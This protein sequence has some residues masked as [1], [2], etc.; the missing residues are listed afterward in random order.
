M[1]VDIELRS[2]DSLTPHELDEIWAVTDRYVETSRPDFEA[3]LRALPEVALW[4]ADNGILIGL[5]SL[6]IY[7]VRCDGRTSIIFFTS[8]VVIDAQFR[9]SNALSRTGMKVFLRETLRRPWLPAYWFF[10]SFSY[11]SYVILTRNLAEFWP[12]RDREMP[13]D[14][15][16]FIDFLARRRYGD[17]WSPETGVVHHSGK[18]RLR[19][20]TAPLDARL[21]ADPDVRF[22]NTM[23]PGHRDGDMLVCL[24]PLRI[25]NLL[26]IVAHAITRR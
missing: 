9:G 18:K 8:S 13:M 1:K 23:N 17:D 6:D 21:L 24:V 2:S 16:R 4:R 19:P 3:K 5:V 22:F 7:R 15:A 11:K 10:D 12:R 25:R 20:E 26:A 14:V